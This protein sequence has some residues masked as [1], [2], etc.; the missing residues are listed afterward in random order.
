MLYSQIPDFAG[1]LGWELKVRWK[2][3]PF[4][5]FTST[6][7]HSK[8]WSEF[9]WNHLLTSQGVPPVRTTADFLYSAALGGGMSVMS[10][11]KRVGTSFCRWY[12]VNLSPYVLWSSMGTEQKWRHASH[13]CY[14]N[15]KAV[16]TASEALLV[17]SCA[18]IPGR[19]KKNPGVKIWQCSQSAHPPGFIAGPDTF[20]VP[21]SW[22]AS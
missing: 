1:W 19:G 12:E 21:Q 2:F 5:C 15:N 4:L 11:I 7:H 13:F 8:V 22:Q 14:R 20:L 9:L 17:F 6:S 10:Y 3:P 16:G 18:S